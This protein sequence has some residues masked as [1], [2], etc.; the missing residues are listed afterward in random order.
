MSIANYSRIRGPFARTTCLVTQAL[1]LHT[2]II[3]Q[4]CTSAN[5]L[6]SV[7]VFQNVTRVKRHVSGGGKGLQPRKRSITWSHKK[8][9]KR[10]IFPKRRGHFHP[11]HQ[12]ISL[13][14]LRTPTSPCRMNGNVN[15]GSDGMWVS[16]AS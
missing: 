7:L 9:H 3:T 16:H 6:E 10:C 2:E 1:I 11:L 8:V 14:P 12:R 15:G 4:K 5:D 13:K